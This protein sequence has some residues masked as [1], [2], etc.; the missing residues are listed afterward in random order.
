MRNK[1]NEKAIKILHGVRIFF[2]RVLLILVVIA[3]GSALLSIYSFIHF[4]NKMAYIYKVSPSIIS[5]GFVILFIVP[6]ISY[7]LE[8]SLS[9]HLKTN[10]NR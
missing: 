9:S 2:E 1:W 4:V 8:K 6:L 7:I 3:I 5:I 10:K